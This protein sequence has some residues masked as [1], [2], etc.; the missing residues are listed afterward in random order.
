MD[1]FIAATAYIAAQ[2]G[3]VWRQVDLPRRPT[4]YERPIRREI[5]GLTHWPGW[6]AF[7]QDLALCVVRDTYA[8][9]TVDKR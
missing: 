4:G 1:P 5:T 3:I 8:N 2:P 7:G 6:E 9:G